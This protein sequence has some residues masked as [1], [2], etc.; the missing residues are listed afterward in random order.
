[1]SFA[2][3]VLFLLGA[4]IAATSPS[5]ARLAEL[6]KIGLPAN[7]DALP[8][9]S[10]FI[11]LDKVT[12]SAPIYTPLACMD[13]P[14]IV[15]PNGSNST[16]LCWLSQFPSFD[17][18]SPNALIDEC[19]GAND[20]NCFLIGNDRRTSPTLGFDYFLTSSNQRTIALPPRKGFEPVWKSVY[21]GHDN[22]GLSFY[23]ERTCLDAYWDGPVLKVHQWGCEFYNRNQWWLFN[24]H[25]DKQQLL[26]H[27]VHTDWCL[28]TNGVGIHNHPQMVKC[29]KAIQEQQHRV[30][31]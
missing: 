14:T 8:N 12:A 28:Q 13:E 5:P 4:T 6:K 3:A 24:M 26:K 19:K 20:G 1:M 18:D 22:F 23:Q 31:F 10:K 7:Y 16:Y 21:L 15:F 17:T 29:N 9:S 2:T 25:S 30:Y 11:P 27:A